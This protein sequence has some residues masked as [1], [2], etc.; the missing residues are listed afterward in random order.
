MITD[1]NIEQYHLA[2]EEASQLLQ[3]AEQ[4]AR[5]KIETVGFELSKRREFTYGMGKIAEK[6]KAQTSLER[7]KE[8]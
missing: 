3:T 2:G 4:K 1:K 5:E 8:V 6:N 7:A